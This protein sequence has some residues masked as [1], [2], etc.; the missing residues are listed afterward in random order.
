MRRANYKP[1]FL[2]VIAFFVVMSIPRDTAD[3]MRFVAISCVA[4]SWKMMS[5]LKSFLAVAP[6]QTAS[7]LQAESREIQR[8][9]LENQMLQSQVES[10][11]EW[12]MFE[13]RLQEQID[14]FSKITSARED[15]HFWK[16]FFQR[17][18]DELANRLELQM[19]ALPA[20]V[21]FR[22]P[23]SWSSSFWLNVGE[24]DNELLGKTVVAK[25]S[26]VVVGDSIVGVVEFVAERKC[27][28]RLI[29]DS[30]LVPSVRA[31]R[32]SEQNLALLE[33]VETLFTHLKKRGDL[34]DSVERE[35]QLFQ[36]LHFIKEKLSS[37]QKD[38][39][40][41]KGELYGTST[42]LWR[43]HNNMLRGTG[44]NYDFSD[45]E[46]PAR[47]LRSGAVLGSSSTDA[48]PILQVG[49]LLVTTGLDGVFPAGYRVATV[50]S[51]GNLRE[52][53]CTYEIEAIA[54]A[55]NLRE[56]HHAFVLPPTSYEAN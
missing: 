10:I 26:P 42:P 38:R 12:I 7:S 5:G 54:T 2:L 13:D 33:N 19:Q 11:R 14:K 35:K 46:G 20:K 28:V 3:K 25:N 9:R 16:E 45:Q 52:G 29:T 49:D 36:G 24:K 39:Y 18:N 51:I 30:G 1:L 40:L 48:L 50:T 15:D 43:C 56:L 47:D 53:G 4:P 55:G 21:I 8:L 37:S 32:G 31:V 6:I 44:F 23:S 41:A 22:D 27:R 34:F 17:R